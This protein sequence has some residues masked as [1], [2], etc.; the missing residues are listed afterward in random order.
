MSGLTERWARTLAGLG[1]GTR[2]QA[3]ARCC[4]VSRLVRHLAHRASQGPGCESHCSRMIPA[5]HRGS[6]RRRSSCT[7]HYREARDSPRRSGSRTDGTGA[8]E[9]GR[10]T[11]RSHMGAGTVTWREGGFARRGQALESRHLDGRTGAGWTAREATR[12][13]QVEGSFTRKET[14]R[15]KTLRGLAIDLTPCRRATKGPGR[16]VVMPFF[17][18]RSCGGGGRA[19]RPNRQAVGCS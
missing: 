5:R 15:E 1:H 16:C 11:G 18:P 12:G 19:S 7:G 14:M 3:R 2:R 10:D 17:F 9:A 6:S 8:A 13:E 4:C